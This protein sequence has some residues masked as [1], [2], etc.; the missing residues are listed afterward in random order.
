L[1]TDDR[2]NPTW[3]IT[4][5]NQNGR[6]IGKVHIGAQKGTVTR[7]EGLFAPPGRDGAQ[8]E[9]ERV[10]RRREQPEPEGDYDAGAAAGAGAYA[11]GGA[12]GADYGDEDLYVDEG[13]GGPDDGDDDD[14]N[15]VQRNI[16]D[17]FRRTRAET[18]RVFENA[19]RSFEDYINRG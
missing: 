13:S 17:F 19:R 4:I 6:Q 3:I 10:V 11:D 7:T 18:R 9:G 2:G 12:G 16:I 14:D 1:R 15:V 8:E 5:H